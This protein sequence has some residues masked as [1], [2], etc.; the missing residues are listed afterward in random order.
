MITKKRSYVYDNSEPIP[1]RNAIRLTKKEGKVIT[2]DDGNFRL[3]ERFSFPLDSKFS[4]KLYLYLD[5]HTKHEV[6]SSY[7]IFES[8]PRPKKLVVI[9]DD[10]VPAP[11]DPIF[12]EPKEALI[13][14]LTKRYSFLQ[15]FSSMNDDISSNIAVAYNVYF[16][17]R[18]YLV[19]DLFG[20][21]PTLLKGVID[22]INIINAADDCRV[23][24]VVLLGNSSPDGESQFNYKLSRS[25]AN[26]LKKYIVRLTNL[27][28]TLIE[29]HNGMIDYDGLY[30]LVGNSDMDDKSA[31]MD[32]IKNCPIWDPKQKVGRKGELMRLN[33]G[34]TY[35]Y[36]EKHFFKKLRNVSVMVYYENIK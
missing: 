33:K 17:N 29:T 18:S 8:S 27:K 31:V 21:N 13:D 23:T 26:E 34:D 10:I 19:D 9:E 24:R 6:L 25:R 1:Y 28:P 5:R 35:R 3:R 7:N 2:N 14:I 32:I 12:E 15:A 22:A 4:L 11:K 30:R 20:E 16:A 36:M